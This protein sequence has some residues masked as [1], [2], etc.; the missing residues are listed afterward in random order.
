MLA[1]LKLAWPYILAAVIGGAIGYGVEH[2]YLGTELANERAARASDSERH[3]NDLSLISK[4][5]L[6][7]EQRAIDTHTVAEGKITTLDQQLTQEKEAH[8]ADNARNRAAIADGTRRLRITVS[9]FRAA[10]SNEA[11]RGAGTGSV[12]DGAGG[13]AELPRPFGL[14]LFAIADDADNDARAK[15]DY[16]QGYVCVLQRQGLIQGTCNAPE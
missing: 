11:D 6:D 13:T 4:A 14:A 3:A 16:L 7:A 12:G 10:G 8:E 9:N 15:A 5:A 1:F 2:L